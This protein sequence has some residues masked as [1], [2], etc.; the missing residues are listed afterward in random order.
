MLLMIDNYDSF[1]FN[2]L[3]WT[4]YPADDICVL[5]ND[6]PR[7][8]RLK[9]SDVSAVIVSPGPM[10]PSEA[11]YSNDIIKNFGEAGIP[12]LGIC[13]GHQCI[14]HLYGCKVVRHPQPA[15]GKQSQVR[16][17][18][19]R[20]FAELP[21]TIDVARYHS[22]HIQTEGFNHDDLK[23]TATMDDGTIMAVEHRDFPIYGVQFHPESVLTGAPGK[24]ILSNFLAISGLNESA[25]HI[26]KLSPCARERRG[27]YAD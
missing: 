18:E 8:A 19:S 2:I 25:Q 16:L 20:L 27:H 21:P 13:L 12:V 22:L 24:K 23:I 4:S 26:Q 11:K 7:L 10:S 6:D 9:P 1:V 17:K 5:R 3:H 14:G 15:H